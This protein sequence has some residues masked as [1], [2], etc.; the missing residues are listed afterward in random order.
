MQ[1]EIRK[2]KSIRGAGIYILISFL[3]FIGMFVGTSIELVKTGLQWSNVIGDNITFP[4]SLFV[5]G[6]FLLLSIILL[7]IGGLTNFITSLVILCTSWKSKWAKSHKIL[8]GILSL[9]ILFF[10]GIIVFG[11][12]GVNLARE[13]GERSY[14]NDNYGQ[15]PKYNNPYQPRDPWNNGNY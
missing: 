3:F 9:L 6:I 14:I 15:Y 5:C 11:A 13:E 7:G 10:I 8:W 4:T 1:S 12:V 2:L